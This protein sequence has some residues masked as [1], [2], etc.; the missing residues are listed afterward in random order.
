LR[1]E[2]PVR[3]QIRARR[4]DH[5]A[6]R[7][8]TWCALGFSAIA[9]SVLMPDGNFVRV[10][11]GVLLACLLLAS[12]HGILSK[13]RDESKRNRAASV[14]DFQLSLVEA[15]HAVSLDGILVVD[16]YENVVACNRQFGEFCGIKLPDRLPGANGDDF[17]LPSAELLAQGAENT[18][19]PKSFIDRVKELHGNPDQDDH[20]QIEL[21]DGRTIERY[22]TVLR[23]NLGQYLGRVWFFRDIS[24]HKLNELRLQEAYHA[25]ESLAITDAL[26]GLANRR[27]F[28][29]YLAAEWRRGL[30]DNYPLSLLLID[31]DLFKAYNDHYGHLNGDACLKQIAEVA[32]DTAT[33]SVDLVARFGGEEFAVIL[34]KTSPEGTVE[35]AEAISENL[36]ARRVP[37]AA[38]PAGI[39]TVSVGCATVT[40]QAG[41]NPAWLI[42]LADQALYRAKRLGRN[43]VCV[44]TADDAANNRQRTI[45]IRPSTAGQ[46][47]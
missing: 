3:T 19:D 44:A 21:K 41:A 34:P 1:R 22:T 4:W 17:T 13:I 33:R 9:F 2:T 29:Q 26:T 27:R 46:S 28:D 39:M 25:V 24:R 10:A 37:H 5:P 32:Q 6:F 23:N 40:P 18:K 15:I 38:S 12:I 8:V 16:E 14:R 45:P 11:N 20:C 30:R 42:E 31:A 43:Q 35:V 7:A 47:S 36:R